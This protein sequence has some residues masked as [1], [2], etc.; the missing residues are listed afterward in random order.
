MRN[1]LG[2]FRETTAARVEQG[3]SKTKPRRRAAGTA[4]LR[5]ADSAVIVVDAVEGVVAQTERVV[6]A[7][8]E[9]R[10]AIVVVVNKVGGRRGRSGARRRF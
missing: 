2:G 1:A 3:P 9:H 10:C 6:A 5:A 4:A 7:A 8:I